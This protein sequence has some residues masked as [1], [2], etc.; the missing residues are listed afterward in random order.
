MNFQFTK[1]ERMAL[2]KDFERVF[3]EGKVFKDA[4]TVFYVRPNE[5]Q[6]SR[7]GL[8]VS[9]KIGNAVR[10]NRAKR[11]LREACRLHKHLLIS[12]FDIIILPR[13]PFSRYL[14]LSDFEDNLKRL[15]RQISE[16]LSK[17]E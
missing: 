8:V 6:H 9:K 1:K 4:F 17:N 12:H 3:R 2:K 10:R 15:F 7:F 13:Y 14:K 16:E 5:Y 11:L